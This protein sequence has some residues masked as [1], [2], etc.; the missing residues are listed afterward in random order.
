M[1]LM[2]VVSLLDFCANPKQINLTDGHK[3][4]N[5]VLSRLLMNKLEAYVLSNKTSDMRE[6]LEHICKDIDNQLI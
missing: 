2:S 3:I 5:A 1:E 6:R 4:G